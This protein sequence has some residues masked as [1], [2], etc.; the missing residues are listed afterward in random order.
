MTNSSEQANQIFVFAGDNLRQGSAQT[1]CEDRLNCVWR[2]R[3]IS[4][5]QALRPGSHALMR[6]SGGEGVKGGVNII[7]QIEEKEI[8][9]S[10]EFTNLAV[11]YPSPHI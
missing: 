11:V 7:Y 5:A 1:L 9:S 2:G 10:D 3:R 6:G 8:L 4:S